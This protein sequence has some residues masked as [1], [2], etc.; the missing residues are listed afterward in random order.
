MVR[1]SSYILYRFLN[2]TFSE[3]GPWAYP[4]G[5]VL[6]KHFSI[7]LDEGDPDNPTKLRKLETRFFVHGDDGEYYGFTYKWRDAKYL[8]L[9]VINHKCLKL[10]RAKEWAGLPKLQPVQLENL[11]ADLNST[12]GKLLRRN[13]ELLFCRRHRH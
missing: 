6:V 10:L 1:H 2:I 11:D 4:K 9:M 13:F 7:P 8:H 3:A 5:T 12:H